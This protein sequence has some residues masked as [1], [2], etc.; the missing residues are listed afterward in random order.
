MGG[1]IWS[2]NPD[3]PMYERTV[4][5]GYGDLKDER[6][7]WTSFVMA[8]VVVVSIRN[9][10]VVY[11]FLRHTS[12]YTIRIDMTRSHSSLPLDF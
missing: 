8:D 6:R 11:R 4:T 9:Q 3:F 10:F 2:I 1:I 5:M 7:G 12:F